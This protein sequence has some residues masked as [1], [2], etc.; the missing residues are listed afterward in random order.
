M[1]TESGNHALVLGG[2]S[3]IDELGN[4]PGVDFADQLVIV[5]AWR[6]SGYDTID[7]TYEAE[8]IAVGRV[9]E[10]A[11]LQKK[12]KVI[13]WNFFQCEGEGILGPTRPYRPDSLDRM[14]EQLRL[15]FIDH[16]VVHPVPDEGEQQ[17]QEEL[18]LSWQ[19]AGRV[20]TL[21]TW[22]PK[23][24][25]ADDYENRIPYQF[26]VRPCNINTPGA[27]AIF[28]EAKQLGWRTLG[29]SPFDRGWLLDKLSKTAHEALGGIFDVHR[30]RIAGLM[31]RYSYF[32]EGMDRLIIGIR[33]KEWIAQNKRHL[34]KGPLG[35]LERLELHSLFEKAKSP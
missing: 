12:I 33:K 31:L 32:V 6:D 4:D 34:H 14:M 10:E 30:E 17:R 9:L 22:D 15:D 18:A 21:G 13:A 8:R 3:F 23:S 1:K 25:L 11:G 26:M 29:T 5:T 16:L 19:A 7:T 27:E 24:S 20:G 2:H 28:R 35:E